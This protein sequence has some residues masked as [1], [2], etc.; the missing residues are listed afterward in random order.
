[1]KIV[2]DFVI[3]SSADETLLENSK[4]EAPAQECNSARAVNS[5]WQKRKAT[6]KATINSSNF[7]NDT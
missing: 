5:C 2:A 3:G 7:F 1:M 4:I 6:R